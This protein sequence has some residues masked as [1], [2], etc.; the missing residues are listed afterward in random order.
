MPRRLRDGT[1]LALSAALLVLPY[2][3]P[4]LWVLA[5]FALVPYFFAVSG[6]FPHQSFKS[7]YFFG[8]LFFAGMGWWLTMVNAFGTVLL[9]AYL[10]LYFAIFGYLACHFINSKDLKSVF[11]A[12]AVWTALEY[13]RGWLIGGLPWALLSYSQ[14]KNVPFIQ[15][16]DIV[17]AFGVSFLLLILNLLIFRILTLARTRQKEALKFFAVL[18]LT[19]GGIVGYGYWK[20]DPSEPPTGVERHLRVSVVQGNIPQDQKW[21]A[22][23]KSII[24]EKY[25]RL[26]SMAALEKADLIIWPETSF[27][28]YLE[29]EPVLASRLRGVVRQSKADVL[30]GAPT[31]GNLDEGLKFYN[32]AILYDSNGEEKKRTH[33]I[34]LVPFGEYIP[35]EP[36]MGVL[37]RWVDIGHFTSGEERTIFVAESHHQPRPVKARFG[38]LICF[39]DIFPW[40]VHDFSSRGVD[41]LVNI[42]N[43][44]WFGKTAAPYQHAAAS[45]FR[46]VENRVPVIRAANTGLSC[47]ISP[48]GRVLASVSDRG[49][50]IFVTGQTNYE[51]MLKKSSS[52][53]AHF[54]DL[55]FLLTV[56]FCYLAYRER[57]KHSGYSQL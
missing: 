30:V 38:V 27:P 36:I 45:V 1:L 54:G 51:L 39:E 29:D 6:K 14:W 48:E 4:D 13:L 47:V 5:F 25:K 17:G 8:F 55:F 15:I 49:E 43:D 24:F 7:S 21:N 31:M 34:H 2:H 19:V 18:C 32:S 33:K 22:K 11:F 28:G 56:L 20:I 41:F 35:F 50:E 40:L 16:A 52:F 9:T 23:I 3:F 26:T 46:A 42:T 10:A 53:Y 57:K 37:R 12:G 44:A